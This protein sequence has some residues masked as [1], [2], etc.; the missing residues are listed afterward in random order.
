MVFALGRWLAASV[1][2]QPTSYLWVTRLPVWGVKR[3]LEGTESVQEGV[4]LLHKCYSSLCKGPS[5]HG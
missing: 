1:T 4:Q 3:D 2:T 5:T